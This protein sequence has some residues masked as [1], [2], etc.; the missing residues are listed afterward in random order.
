MFFI[1]YVKINLGR[2]SRCIF[3][4]SFLPSTSKE[5]GY[6]VQNKY[7]KTEDGEKKAESQGAKDPKVT[8][9]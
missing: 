9:W 5:P 4:Y 3:P 7:R 2:W 8:W 1:N 6:Y